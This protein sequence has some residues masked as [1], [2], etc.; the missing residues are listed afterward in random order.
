MS[1]K[2]THRAY[3]VLDPKEGSDKKPY[4]HDVGAVWQH[5]DGK[6]FDVVIPAGLSV[7]QRR[8]QIVPDGGV[9]VYQPG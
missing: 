5:G 9:K 7:C 3:I 1:S 6:G 8:R 2:P 4:W